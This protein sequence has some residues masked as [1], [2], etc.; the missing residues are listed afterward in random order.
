M[1]KGMRLFRW[2]ALVGSIKHVGSARLKAS[3]G[4]GTKKILDL[5][6][7]IKMMLRECN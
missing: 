6:E 1:G 3:V 7:Q 2:S 4:A 5:L